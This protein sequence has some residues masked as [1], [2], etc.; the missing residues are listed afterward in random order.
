MKRILLTFFVFSQIALSAKTTIWLTGLPCVGKTTLANYIHEKIPNSVILDGDAVQKNLN[1]DLGFTPE[2]RKENLRHISEMANIILDSVP[3]VLISVVSPKQSARDTAREMI[4]AKCGE[5]FEVFVNAPLEECIS[6]DVKGMYKKA[7]AGEIPFFTG[8]GAPY[9]AP[10][11]PDVVCNT[12]IETL[13]E[14]AKKN[15]K[16]YS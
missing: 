9:E 6:R 7:L 14:S 1:S 2:D 12:L 4:E 11:N 15:S 8:I 16:G 13:E 5:F 3:V 10:K